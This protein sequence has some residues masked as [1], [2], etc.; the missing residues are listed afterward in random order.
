MRACNLIKNKT[1]R[2][3]NDDLKFKSWKTIIESLSFEKEK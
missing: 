3:L 1:N 2:S